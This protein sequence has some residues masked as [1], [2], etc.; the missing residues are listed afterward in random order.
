MFI[1]KLV[2]RL[3]ISFRRHGGRR[4]I[5]P[6]SLRGFSWFHPEPFEHTPAVD[7]YNGPVDVLF[8]TTSESDVA[9]VSRKPNATR[10]TSRDASHS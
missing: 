5:I 2:V 6:L 1:P 7:F 10:G 8:D 4:T 9:T 3:I